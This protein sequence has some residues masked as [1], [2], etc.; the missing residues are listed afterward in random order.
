MSTGSILVFS[1]IKSIIQN[2]GFRTQLALISL[3]D[4]FLIEYFSL[5]HSFLLFKRQCTEELNLLLIGWF[6]LIVNFE[7]RL[8]MLFNFNIECLRFDIDKRWI[9]NT[10]YRF[11]GDQVMKVTGKLSKLSAC[12]LLLPL[13]LFNIELSLILLK[14]LAHFIVLVLHMAQVSL[15][16]IKVMLILSTVVTTITIFQ[17][18]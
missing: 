2:Y 8:E 15:S 14:L 16:C 12:S 11:R 10:W 18:S 17:G 4:N 6:P 9:V 7:C 5:L 13:L 3:I 1:L